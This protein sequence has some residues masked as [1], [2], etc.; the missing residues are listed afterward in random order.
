MK[1]LPPTRKAFAFLFPPGS[2][3][4]LLVLFSSIS[5]SIEWFIEAQ[6]FSLSYDLAT[7]PPLLPQ[8]FIEDQAFSLSYDLATPPPLLPQWFI[9][10]QAFSLSY[11][12]APP[13]PPPP[14]P[15]ASCL[16][17]TFFLC[18]A[19]LAYWRERGR[20]VKTYGGSGLVLYK[21]LNTLWSIPSKLFLRVLNIPG[22][23]LSFLLPFSPLI[24]H[25]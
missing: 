22:L 4:F 18:V 9:E 24:A 23:F 1:L 21:T 14:I 13:Q 25:E 2:P 16:S 6:A 5:E 7:P 20:G 19:G 8:W 10:D 17:F 15:S 11:G 3:A 12:L